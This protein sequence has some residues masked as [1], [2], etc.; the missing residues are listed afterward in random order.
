MT[1]LVSII[2]ARMGSNRLPGKVLMPLINEYSSLEC[3]INRILKSKYISRDNL[4]IAT[5]E[6]PQDEKIN[7]ECF[8]LGVKCFRGSENNVLKRFYEATKM[9]SGNIEYIIRLTAD[10]PLH[11][12]NVIDSF[13]EY[14]FNNKVDYMSNAAT[15]SFPK[16][17]DIEI[18][19]KKSLEIAYQ[20]ATLD[21][22]KEHVTPYIRNNPDQFKTGI[23]TNDI[24]LSHHRWTLDYEDDYKM[25]CTI[26]KELYPENPNFKMMDIVKL[27]EE[28]PDIY[29]ITSHLPRN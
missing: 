24:N 18:M 5:S 17:L 9:V 21:F 12:P 15:R 22:E 6:L 16:G 1:N 3:M 4:I 11:D 10:C 25:I 20:K 19:T 28:R 29:E 27:L 8:K 23:F 13:L 14:F 7:K 2:Q 26:Y